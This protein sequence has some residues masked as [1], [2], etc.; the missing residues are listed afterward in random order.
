MFAV[1]LIFGINI[2]LSKSL[3]PLWISPEG[4]T[5]SR[6]LFGTVVF[7]LA[8]LFIATEKVPF[9]DHRFFLVGSLCGVVFNQGLFIIG[10]NMTSPVDASIIITA[11]PLF[12]MIF[13]ALLLKEPISFLKVAGILLGASGAIMLVYTGHHGSNAH[14]SSLIGNLMVMGSSLIYA[15]YLVFTKPL[16]LRYHPITLMKWLFLYA[17]VMVTPFYYHSLLSA[18]VFQQPD[19]IALLQMIYTLIFATFLAY[20]LIPMAQ[21]RIRPTTIS[22]YNNF[23]PLVASFVAISVG[24]DHFSLIK[25]F[26]AILIFS[27]VFLVT[28]S[29][30]KPEKV[31]GPIDILEEPTP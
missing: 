1:T 11:G 9:R 3:L 14:D 27:G 23:Q 19:K 15:F 7:W 31:K 25:M 12:A 6:I 5:L 10:L 16:T 30:A 4:L 28:R 18:H 29:R 26:S 2:P 20:L 13:A 22:M 17:S 24:M 8:S 21:Q